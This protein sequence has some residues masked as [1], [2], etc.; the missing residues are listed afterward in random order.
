MNLFLG[1]MNCQ[2]KTLFRR[3]IW[4]DRKSNEYMKREVLKV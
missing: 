1:Q 4:S 2:K 3:V